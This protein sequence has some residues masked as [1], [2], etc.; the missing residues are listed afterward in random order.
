M[1]LAY[2]GRVGRC[3][4]YKSLTFLVRLFFC[5]FFGTT[6][7]LLLLPNTQVK[8]LNAMFIFVHSVMNTVTNY[9]QFTSGK[10][11]LLFLF[12]FFFS[13]SKGGDTLSVDGYIN[14]AIEN[15]STGLLT[16]IKQDS[17]QVFN[18][19][20]FSQTTGGLRLRLTP[21]F[22]LGKWYDELTLTELGSND[23]VLTD[24]SVTNVNYLYGLDAS[25][26]FLA[27]YSDK[28]G[29]TYMNLVF[30]RTA[31]ESRFANSNVK[32]V[33]FL[34]NFAKRVG[35][36]RFNYGFAKNSYSLQ[37]NGGITDSLVYEN[38]LEL[39]VYTVPVL[40][41]AAKSSIAT[42]NAYV[43]N[44]YVLNYIDPNDSSV[45]DSVQ[46]KHLHTFGYEV[47]FRKEQYVYSMDRA[48]IDSGIFDTTLINLN[49]T[50]DSLG[51]SKRGYEIYYQLLDSN[52]RNLFKLAH[53][54]SHYDWNALDKSFV[55]FTF[56]NYG[57]G[58]FSVR[59]SYNL[60]G[61]WKNGYT[62]SVSHHT[63]ISR[64]WL[65]SIEYKL[66]Y[67]LPGYFYLKYQGNH[68][69]WDN[70]FTKVRNQ[71][72]DYSLL[73]KPSF[74]GLEAKVQLLDDWIYMDTLSLPVQLTEQ[75][76][77]LNLG[78]FNTYKSKHISVYTKF[79]YQKSSSDVLRFPTYNLRNVFTYNLK[80]GELKFTAGYIFTY[81]TSFTG[82]DYNP[83]LRRTYL[84]NN[85]IVGGIP[86]LDVFA[87]VKI[88][89]ANVFV[90]GEN[91]L[92]ESVS[93]AYYLYPN[94]PVLPRYIRVGF[95]W[96]FKN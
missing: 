39:T 95:S 69:K 12:A 9:F 51:F 23:F 72:I 29:N 26:E 87:T 48:D 66:D 63:K 44:Q 55:S 91:V 14:D 88:G 52:N 74:T 15:D 17:K 35:E 30:D 59:G 60:N 81:F 96:V 75:I 1:V 46:P 80:L 82:L 92:F 18:P 68:F 25:H 70:A 45:A 77:Y 71:S 2:A 34:L 42:T 62:M 53:N 73:H 31:S 27:K 8:N 94:R 16:V 57:L 64:S 76:Q 47:N 58:R 85:K 37:H 10:L 36:N 28:V 79:S 13:I 43:G 3:R 24:S 4:F 61:L 22:T 41:H 6:A 11:I 56:S 40:L 86:L 33:G 5:Q 21:Q 32:N 54:Y 7:F 19:Y 38:A 78:L 90:K 65:N 83:N 49:E 93:R 50:W 20:L 84:Q 89:E 67:N